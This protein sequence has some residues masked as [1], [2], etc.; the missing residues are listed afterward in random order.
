M[1]SK[2]QKQHK[3]IPS[4]SKKQR[5]GRTSINSISDESLLRIM[6]LLIPLPCRRIDIKK[7]KILK[8]E[9]LEN[10][11]D[12]SED[13]SEDEDQDILD[14][15]G[16]GRECLDRPRNNLVLM[17][18]SAFSSTSKLLNELSNT[19]FGSLL[20]MQAAG[21]APPIGY[22]NA[23]RERKFIL[24]D[25]SSLKDVN[26]KDRVRLWHSSII[27]PLCI[28]AKEALSILQRSKRVVNSRLFTHTESTKRY[29]GEDEG[30]MVDGVCDNT[31]G[32]GNSCDQIGKMYDTMTYAMASVLIKPMDS[33]STLQPLV[34]ACSRMYHCSQCVVESFKL[35]QCVSKSNGCTF[36]RLCSAGLGESSEP[37]HFNKKQVSRVAKILVGKKSTLSEHQILSIITA[38]LCPDWGTTDNPRDETPEFPFSGFDMSDFFQEGEE[39]NGTQI[40]KSLGADAMAL[41]KDR[42]TMG[43]NQKLQGILDYSCGIVH[44]YRTKT[45]KDGCFYEE[46]HD[47]CAE[48]TRSVPT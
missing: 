24:G 30:C 16:Y 36:V 11:S 42:N 7:K 12:D 28:E 23:E 43:I 3:G 40:Y 32:G 25:L 38:S 35:A 47:M 5:G 31:C 17:D 44:D 46:S 20:F 4:K 41:K 2:S 26:E 15:P 8:K 33:N 1:S 14:Y 34:F 27:R 22:I 29:N 6:K 18:L 21:L 19:P 13:D 48:I 37:M 10:S 45:F 39:R 9:M